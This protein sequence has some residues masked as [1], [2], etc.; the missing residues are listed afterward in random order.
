[1]VRMTPCNG[2]FVSASIVLAAGRRL[3]PRDAGL[4]SPQSAEGFLAWASRHG[5]VLGPVRIAPSGFGGGVGMFATRDVEVDE[6]LFSVPQRMHLGLDKALGDVECAEDFEEGLID[7]TG[8]SSLST[9]LAK[10]NLCNDSVFSPYFN[11]LSLQTA[12]HVQFWSKPELDLFEGTA[13]H[14]PAMVMR[15]DADDIVEFALGLDSLRR[16]VEQ[17]LSSR[18]IDYNEDAIDSLIADYVRSAYSLVMS[19]GFGDSEVLGGR[20]L[21]PV[22]DKLQHGKPVSI[23]FRDEQSETSELCK[24]ARAR[25]SISAGEEIFI[26]YGDH[27]NYVFA[28]VYGFVPSVS[29]KDANVRSECILALGHSV[30]LDDIGPSMAREAQMQGAELGKGQIEELVGQESHLQLVK[31]MWDAGATYPLSFI[32]TD[33]MIDE[34]IANAAAGKRSSNAHGAEAFVACAR[35]CSLNSSDF[36]EFAG[37]GVES[38]EQQD[39]VL[40][41]LLYSDD[42]RIS[43]ENDRKAA[44]LVR[45]TA[46]EQLRRL[47]LPPEPSTS[48]F[49]APR[50]E[51][52]RLASRMRESEML[53]LRRLACEDAHRLF[54]LTVAELTS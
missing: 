34:A 21:I 13:A 44:Q 26:S 53:V 10:L 18:G 41:Q 4:G 43:E 7:G 25:R 16:C 49:S 46:K 5:C 42:G 24:V 14:E 47:E 15:E 30:N 51:C 52:M 6:L 29:S 9:Y 17:S 35:L 20:S 1:M 36:I 33:D 8:L 32:V 3:L 31:L 19:R 28:T 37:A 23:S 39:I 2:V 27:P 50:E 40:S 22:L 48:A 12:D 45:E 54:G 11:T 38:A